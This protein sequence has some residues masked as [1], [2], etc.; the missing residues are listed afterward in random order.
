[1]LKFALLGFLNY[2]PMTGYELENYIN[3]STGNFWHAKLSQIYATLKKLEQ[4]DLVTSHVEAQE[5]RPDRRVYTLTDAGRETLQDWLAQPITDYV[6]KKDDL[7]LKI[8]FSRPIGKD[9]I[10]TQLRIQ[11]DVHRRKQ[12][13]YEQETPSVIQSILEDFPELAEDATLWQAVLRMGMMHEEMYVRWLEET[14]QEIE[15]QISD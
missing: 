5:D 6:P 2:F 11:L 9:A 12:Q 3:V 8:F 14:I 15:R 1:M 10:L 13:F 4:D 7:L